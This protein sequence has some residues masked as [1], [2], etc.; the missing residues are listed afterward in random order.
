VQ[1]KGN[2]KVQRQSLTMGTKI[3]QGQEIIL[4]LS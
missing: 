3:K 2:G 1:L 4:N